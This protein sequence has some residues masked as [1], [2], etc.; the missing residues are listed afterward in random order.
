MAVGMTLSYTSPGLP[1]ITLKWNLSSI[2]STLFNA[3]TSFLAVL[4]APLVQ[5]LVGRTGRRLLVFISSIVVLVGWVLLI[6]CPVGQQKWLLFVSR[7]VSGV[8][9]GLVMTISPIFLSEIS[10]TEYR[11]AYGVMSQLFVSIGCVF[12]Y[13]MGVWLDYWK[14]AFISMVPSMILCITIFFF[15]DS[16]VSIDNNGFKSFDKVTIFRKKYVKP[17]LLSI[18]TVFFQQF[19]GFNGLLT[20]LQTIFNNVGLVLSPS[21]SAAIVSCAQVISTIV[22]SF[23]VDKFGRR[24]LWSI[25]SIG[26]AISLFVIFLDDVISISNYF[27]I[28]FLFL[29]VFL[30]GLGLGPLPWFISPEL[31]TDDV[32]SKAYSIVQAVNSILCSC[33]IFVIP[34]MISGLTMRYTFLTFSILMVLS[35]LFG[36][37]LLPETSGK[38]MGEDLN[39]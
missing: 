33:V 13:L 39:V 10:P 36:L 32:R 11:G 35:F 21:I 4:G 2:E 29:Y 25:S 26:T 5:L 31:F 19:S 37:L 24:I 20:N 30:F 7:S 38:E 27:P 28:I 9:I 16:K 1:E 34:E 17:L 6:V 3:I 23:I 8:G 18:A 22:S 12:I 15:P 14:I